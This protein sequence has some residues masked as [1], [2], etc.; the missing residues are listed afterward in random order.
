MKFTI[1][2][3]RNESE[4][5]A[6]AAFTAEGCNTLT[7]DFAAQTNGDHWHDFASRTCIVAGRLFLTDSDSGE[8]YE[9]GPGTVIVAPPRVVH[10]EVTDG[11]RAVIALDV[12]VSTLSQP[13]LKDPADL[14]A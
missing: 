5:D 12:D 7:V 1:E 13:I 2:R 9:L 6:V 10:R 8:E 3:D 14:H 11:Y 4:A